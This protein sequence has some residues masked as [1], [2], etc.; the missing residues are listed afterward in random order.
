[1]I[2]FHK[3]FTTEASTIPSNFHTLQNL[4]TFNDSLIEEKIEKY[5]FL[6]HKIINLKQNYVK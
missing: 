4:H 1:M 6:V 3:F 5:L 2:N